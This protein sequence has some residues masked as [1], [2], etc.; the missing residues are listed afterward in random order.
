MF[1]CEELM[2]DFKYAYDTDNQFCFTEYESKD[3]YK[4]QTLLSTTYSQST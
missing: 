1:V 3:C 4:L 2:R